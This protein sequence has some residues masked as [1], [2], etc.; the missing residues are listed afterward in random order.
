MKIR[1]AVRPG[2][3]PE[4]RNRTGQSKSHKGAIFHLFVKK[5]PLNRFSQKICAVVAVLDVIMSA[6]FWAEICRGYDFTGGRIS[7]FHIDSFLG[8]T[9][10]HVI[11]RHGQKFAH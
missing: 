10:V 7:R 6:N 1:T 4:K 2:R 3:V 5:S 9:T 8:L 11:F